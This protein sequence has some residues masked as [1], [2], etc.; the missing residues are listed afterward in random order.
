MVAD[1]AAAQARSDAA[2]MASPGGIIQAFWA[3]VTTTSRSQASISRGMAPTALTPSTRM[4]VPGTSARMVAASSARGLVTP[5]EVSLKV[6]STACGAL[7][8]CGHVPEGIAN[9][10]RIGSPAP[11]ELEHGH[12][13]GV[14][15]GDLGEALA[16]VADAHRQHRVAGRKE[17]DDGC[18]ETARARGCQDH[19]VALGLERGL[20]ALAD[21]GDELH[22]LGP[23]V[24][25]HLPRAGLTHGVG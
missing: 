13:G 20:H 8:R 23:T 22:E 1:S 10:V 7:A 17:A 3:P 9:R 14:G 11:V 21:A 6:T 16:E 25:H 24:A 12:I 15:L 2:T 4:S 5:V 18:L 19:H